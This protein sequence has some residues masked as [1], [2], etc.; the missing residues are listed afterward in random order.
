MSQASTNGP[1]PIRGG[2]GAPILGPRNPALER[3]NPELLASPYTDSGT[4][5]NLKFSFAAAR[6]RLLTGGWAREVTVRELPI[7]TQL[8][9]VNM[10]LKAGGIRELHW[11]KEAEW[12][13]LI[14]GSARLT[15]V[16]AQG[17]NFIGD[18]DAGDIW[19]FPAGIPH[20]IQGLEAGCEF[21]LVF[22]DG[23]FSENETF[24]ITDWF[25]HTPP[26]VLAKNFGVPESAFAAIPLDVEHERY[27]FSGDVPGPIETDAVASPAGT[28]PVPYTHRLMAQEPVL[29]AGGTAR[30]VDSSN[31][32][33]AST[34]AAALVEVEPG[35]MREL[36]WHPTTDEWQY[37]LSGRGRMTVF[38]SAGKARTFDYSEGD[39]G[40][41]P[42]AMGHYIEN[43]GDE[44]L[45]FLELFR[46]D[47]FADISLS[48][49]M[50]LT[51]P[52]L[53]RAHLNLEQQTVDSL[54]KDKPVVV[55]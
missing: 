40:Y 13:Y 32:P 10:R 55:R 7:A 5:P 1:A 6:N 9:G 37:Y 49:W 43:T 8:A 54:P 30:I 18:V 46:S 42:F 48:Q 41:I 39:V 44:T 16:D 28:V 35:G 29:A 31:F 36:H 52:E 51:P 50:A 15:A 53:V 26:E 45:R 38:A 17:R 27:I 34:I 14:A 23:N 21:L 22:D 25:A 24:L 47:R 2:L 4:V 3:E 20:S 33:A 12:G 19:N 11:H